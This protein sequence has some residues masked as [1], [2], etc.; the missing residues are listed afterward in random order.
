MVSKFEV[1]ENNKLD[2]FNQTKVMKIEWIQTIDE[3]WYEEYIP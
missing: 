3:Y 2:T 1:F